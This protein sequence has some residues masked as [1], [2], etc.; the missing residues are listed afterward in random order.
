MFDYTDLAFESFLEE[1][2]AGNMELLKELIAE[3][4]FALESLQNGQIK[5]EYVDEAIK[6]VKQKA[7]E[8]LK[9]FLNKVNSAYIAATSRFYETYVDDVAAKADQIKKK[10][11]SASINIAP[12]WKPNYEADLS[13]VKKVLGDAFKTPYDDNDISFI[14]S[15]IPSINGNN[16]YTVQDYLDYMSKNSAE[17]TIMIKNRFRFGTAEPNN[18]NIKKEK[19]EGG[20]LAGKVDDMIKYISNYKQFSNNVRKISDEWKA[21]AKVFE[22]TLTESANLAQDTLLMIEGKALKDTDLALLEGF[23]ALPVSEAG[24]NDNSG[25]K[26]PENLNKVEDNIAPKKD[27]NGDTKEG[28]STPKKQTSKGRY[29]MCDKFCK[30]VYTSYIFSIEDRFIVYIHALETILGESLKKKDKQE[31]NDNQSQ[32]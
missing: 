6:D 11:S 25:D 30:L 5:A 19:L 22:D 26:K 18:E 29:D 15:I 16:N 27:E 13:V 20:N 32:K 12:Y 7:G 17:V 23:D 2:E 10:A 3:T 9:I 1:M 24:E 14:K 8:I 28:E 4:K 31:N 21:K